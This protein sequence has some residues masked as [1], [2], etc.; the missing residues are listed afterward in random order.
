MTTL[1]GDVAT[2][3]YDTKGQLISD[4]RTGNRS[5]SKAY[6]Y[7]PR[8]NRVSLTDSG[9]ATAYTYNTANQL[10]NS[11]KSSITT[12]YTYDGNGNT[13]TETAGSSGAATYTYD[14]ENQLTG[15]SGDDVD[16][17]YTYYANGLRKTKTVDDVT[18]TYVWDGD[19]LVYESGSSTYKYIRGLTLIA[20]VLGSTNTK[21]H[22]L[23]EVLKYVDQRQIRNLYLLHNPSA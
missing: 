18:T 14:V 20:S 10:L 23:D 4:M 1:S 6:T 2:Y 21:S 3:T 5:Y 22:L 17:A 9:T 13:L 19:Q 16:A 11:T 8:G 12:A 7:D 15:I